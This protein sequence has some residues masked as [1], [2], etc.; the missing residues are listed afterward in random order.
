MTIGRQTAEKQ[1]LKYHSSNCADSKN[2]IAFPRYRHRVFVDGGDSCMSLPEEATLMC[3][4]LLSITSL[5][6][7][8]SKNNMIVAYY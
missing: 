5:E 6:L 4:C 1:R 8:V 2:C 7:E 3:Q